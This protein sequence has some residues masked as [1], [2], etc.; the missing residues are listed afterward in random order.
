MIK[1]G[2]IDLEAG[3]LG[4]KFKFEKKGD[5]LVGHYMGS[6]VIEINGSPATKHKFMQDGKLIAPLGSADLDRQ[7][8]RVTEGTLTRV[9]FLGKEKNTKGFMMKKFKISID[10]SSSVP[11]SSRVESEK[12]LG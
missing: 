7:L 11:T 4:E 5:E 9:V 6:E 3:N 1:M 10:P 8:S 2:W 12:S